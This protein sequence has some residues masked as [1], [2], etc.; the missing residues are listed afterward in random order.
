MLYKFVKNGGGCSLLVLYFI[1][2]ML[3]TCF[4]YKE[5]R[6]RRTLNIYFNESFSYYFSLFVLF[7]SVIF[8]ILMVINFFIKSL[9]SKDS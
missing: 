4:H 2:E 9:D 7:V 5:C 8:S 6:A 1:S 3:Y